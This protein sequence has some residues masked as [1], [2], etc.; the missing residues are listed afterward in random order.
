MRRG[1]LATVVIT[2]LAVAAEAT[3]GIHGH[4]PLGTGGLLGVGG[5]LLLALGAKALGGAGLQR[6]EREDAEGG[7]P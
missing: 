2:L 7:R 3:L 4:W 5:S 6:P 1:L